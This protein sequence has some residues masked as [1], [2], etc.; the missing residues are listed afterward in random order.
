MIINKMYPA[1]GLRTHTEKK[2]FLCKDD[3]M[4]SFT[5]DDLHIDEAHRVLDVFCFAGFFVEIVRFK[6]CL[7]HVVTYSRATYL[8]ILLIKL[9]ISDSMKPNNANIRFS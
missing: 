5:L 8:I 4:Q 2:T 3:L 6:D 7:P 1:L 9:S